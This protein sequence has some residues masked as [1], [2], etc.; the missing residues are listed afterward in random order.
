MS[1]SHIPKFTDGKHV[2]PSKKFFLK[3]S[4]LIMLTSERDEAGELINEEISKG[5]SKNVKFYFILR[6]MWGH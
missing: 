2:D 1:I 6:K 4:L 3:K 5:L